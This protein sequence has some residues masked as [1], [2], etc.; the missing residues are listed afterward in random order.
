M[1]QWYQQLATYSDNDLWSR[2]TFQNYGSPG[3]NIETKY[4]GTNSS[5]AQQKLL[6]VKAAANCGGDLKP[7]EDLDWVTTVQLANGQNGEPTE[8]QLRKNN[9]GWDL[10]GDKPVRTKCYGYDTEWTMYWAYRSLTFG[11]NG[12]PQALWDALAWT[13]MDVPGPDPSW[14]YP[15]FI[16]IDPSNGFTGEIAPNA[17]AYPFRG[18]G[19]VTL[20]QVMRSDSKGD[21]ES[22]MSQSAALFENVTQY[23]PE[24]GAYYNY[25]DK[26]MGAY[27]AVP[28]HSYYGANADTV[29]DYLRE[30]TEGISMQDGCGRCQSWELSQ[31]A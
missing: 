28:R 2:L 24:K 8:E 20:Q 12:V 7:E 29:E 3:V 31:S 13:S 17:T 30:Y 6:D 15:F 19:F 27:G 22:L 10:D 18:A 5:P 14:K 21:I 23:A 9:C 16:E 1:S 25:L 26:D 11:E 4:F